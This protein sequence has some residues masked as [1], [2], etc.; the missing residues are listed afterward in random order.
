[1]CEESESRCVLRNWH[2]TGVSLLDGPR[3]EAMTF[4]QLQAWI[5]GSDAKKPLLGQRSLFGDDE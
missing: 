5:D 1:M 4:E 3:D 2:V